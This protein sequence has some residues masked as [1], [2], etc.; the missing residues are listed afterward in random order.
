M[1]IVQ[2]PEEVFMA[3]F[4]KALRGMLR[5]GMVNNT[6]PIAFDEPVDNLHFTQQGKQAF[7]KGVIAENIEPFNGTIAFQP[8]SINK[9][10]TKASEVKSV[11]CESPL[12]MCRDLRPDPQEMENHIV[13]E[14]MSYGA[15][16]GAEVFDIQFDEP[17]ALK[18]IR[19]TV[20]LSLNKRTGEFEIINNEYNDS[21]LKNWYSS[22]DLI[23]RI[24]DNVTSFHDNI[25]VKRW[26]DSD[27]N[28]D[29]MTFLVPFDIKFPSNGLILFDQN[30]CSSSKYES[31]GTPDGCDMTVINTS[32]HG[33]EYAFI[34]RS[35]AVTG[36]EGALECNIVA[37]RTIGEEE[38]KDCVRTVVNKIDL[39]EG[40]GLSRALQ[41]SSLIKDTEL[42]A[43]VAKLYLDMTPLRIAVM[44]LKK[45]SKKTWSNNIPELVEEAMK[46]DNYDAEKIA[47]ELEGTDLKISG[48]MIIPALMTESPETNLQVIDSLSNILKNPNKMIIDM[49][50]NG[51]VSKSIINGEPFNFEA[52]F[53]TL[54]SASNAARLMK[55]LKKLFGM[56][57]LS[58]YSFDLELFDPE[59][60]ESLAKDASTFTSDVQTVDMIIR[61][62]EEYREIFEYK[63][64]F[65]EMGG[66]FSGNK[67]SS[68]ISGIEL[69][70]KLEDI[71]R[72]MNLDGTLHDMLSDARDK[73]LLSEDD[74]KQLDL[75]RE[76]RNNCAHQITIDPINKKQ[77]DVWKKLIKKLEDSVKP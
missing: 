69:G 66:F 2:I 33:Y 36:H 77:M 1:E 25:S 75:L 23:K 15:D 12:T 52:N 41:L 8:A 76:Y 47:K 43:N 53:R 31:Y 14:M 6:G 37:Q 42:S 57:S 54:A 29:N 10:Y 68:R 46:K 73:E 65:E 40:D 72:S 64:F 28:W 19:S 20:R 49:R 63:T 39:S 32:G 27:P 17:D 30:A 58:E 74:F 67:S 5:S 50:M 38:I 34:K 4:E 7:E 44:E 16:R 3:V 9:R 60:R 35:T 59:S 51:F 55:K 70:V 24:P 56:K 48:S 11:P 21:F 22:E 26:R 61:N 18:C 71:L 13:R 62:T 45:Y